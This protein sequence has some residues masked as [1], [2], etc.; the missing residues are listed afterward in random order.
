LLQQLPRK[1][2]NHGTKQKRENRFLTNQ[3]AAN[4]KDYFS[5][6]IAARISSKHTIT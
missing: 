5:A 4:Q 6:I 2:I 3:K 1:I